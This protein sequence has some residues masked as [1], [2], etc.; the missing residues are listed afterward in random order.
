[1]SRRRSAARC[2]LITAAVTLAIATGPRLTGQE[3]APVGFLAHAF[4]GTIVKNG[5][6][7][8][9]YQP[10]VT[11]SPVFLNDC[12]VA[13]P[14]VVE[15]IPN[16]RFEV[17]LR[18]GSKRIG[19]RRGPIIILFAPEPE[20]QGEE[21]LP[22]ELQEPTTD[23]YGLANQTFAL[24]GD[25]LI[26][27]SDRGMVAKVHN[28]RGA[29][30]T[31][32]V[33]G[34]RKLSV[35][36]F[37]DLRAT[38][39]SA[40]FP[41]AAFTRISTVA[42]LLG[43]LSTSGCP[44]YGWACAPELEPGHVLVIDGVIE[45]PDSLPSLLIPAG[46]TLRGD[47]RGVRGTG[48]LHKRTAGED[49][50]IMLEVV[51]HN[52]R[53]TG[54]H[55]RGPSRSSAGGQ[56]QANG[57]RVRED[58][59]QGTII[60]HNDIG[61]W[62]WR[63]VY[64]LGGQDR[65][66]AAD[67]ECTDLSIPR[68]RTSATWVARNFIHHNRE[69]EKGY[70][71]NTNSGAFPFIEGN[72]FYENRHAIAGT[73]STS[74]TGY[75]A[76]RNFVLSVAPLQRGVFHT[77]D[78]DMHGTG[79]GGKGG[80]AG[81]YMDL[82]QNTFLGT[83]RHNF[84]VR[85]TPCDFVEFR[86]NVS[87]QERDDALSL[88]TGLFGTGDVRWEIPSA[89]DQFDLP[90]PTRHQ[91]MG[92]GDFDG[93]GVQDAFIATGTAWYY[94]PHGVAEW[95][96]LNDHPDR[97]ATLKFGDFDGDGRTDVLGKNGLDLVVSWGGVS[98]WEQVN[99]IDAPPSDL[100]VG[101]F[102]ASGQADLFYSDGSNWFVAYDNGPFVLTQTSGFRVKDLRFG[103]FDADGRTDVFG[104]VS[105]AWRVSYGATSSWTFLRSKLSDDVAS[106]V[107][108]DFDGDRAADI[109]SYSVQLNSV[110][111][112]PSVL[113]RWRVSRGGTSGWETLQKPSVEPPAAIGRFVPD[114][115][116][117]H[118]LVWDEN[119]WWRVTLGGTSV[120]RHARQHMR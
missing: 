63:G 78:F 68:F 30:G 38:D 20:P 109:G 40:S 83:N 8:L 23:S 82:Y 4:N 99:Q 21:E 119:T 81:G 64:V 41:T 92:V 43:T 120:T 79:D 94:A 18:A 24:D 85:G 103:D 47:R 116:K 117:A 87:L 97:L 91:V 48:R 110:A 7:C 29:N 89:P 53:V 76:W 54:L 65:D 93:D 10:E 15:T 90:D 14:I 95:R 102:D 17:F 105:N 50:E 1:M 61:D 71:V 101:D 25:S 75:R 96:L 72:V 77:H 37:W 52:S 19:V 16:Q 70:G 3:P 31:P 58:L 66:N 12:A 69:Y 113:Y 67:L 86:N 108:A 36:E 46:T 106:L 55:L 115:P 28:A 51:G 84:E 35:E 27:A 112:T 32:I 98:E 114:D 118:L 73:A 104:V 107:V 111:T 88:D 62:T 60:D 34:A 56:D 11:G 74:G 2:L 42:G 39:G 33:A 6:K 9:D 45:L 22:L 80:R 57:I 59:V 100:A 26:L 49:F 13:H 44:T 5:G